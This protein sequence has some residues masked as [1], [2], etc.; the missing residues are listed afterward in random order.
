MMTMFTVLPQTTDDELLSVINM[1]NQRGGRMLSMVDLIEAGTVSCDMAAYFHDRM[2][3]G[4]SVLTCAAPGGVGKTA[5]LGAILG[6]LP[7]EAKLVTVG[8]GAANVAPISC[9]G[10]VWYL[11]HEIGNG[12]FYGYLW[13]HEV[14]KLLS[15]IGHKHAIAAT[16]HADTMDEL[17]ALLSQD[18]L[19]VSLHELAKVDI[20]AF[21]HRVRVE[22][23][24]GFSRRVVA[25]FASDG[26]EQ[27]LAFRWNPATD[28]HERSSMV[29][30]NV[31]SAKLFRELVRRGV[32]ELAAVRIAINH[33]HN[34]AIQQ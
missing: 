8:A 2:Q 22:G 34:D 7:R 23:I 33:A 20:I 19:Q 16:A 28:T 27:H 25:V 29:N 32:K 4:A 11:C 15:L 5:L 17:R 12:P 14:K 3:E 10:P 31:Q 30:P 24:G 18:D 21:I 26:R 9:Q 13:G 1:M 6:L